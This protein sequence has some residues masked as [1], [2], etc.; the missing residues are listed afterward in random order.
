MEEIKYY[1]ANVDD[2]E[3]LA[4][5]R[6]KFIMEFAGEQP[7]E[8]QNNLKIVLTDYFRT[9][10]AQN[11]CINY[12][13]RSANEIAGTGGLIYRI[14]PGNFKNPTGRSGYIMNMFTLPRFRKK[15]ICTSILNKLID[16][17][18]AEGVILFELHATE[19]GRPIY[20]SNGFKLHPEPTLRRYL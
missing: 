7:E 1:K 19:A 8:D 12:I 6:I 16:D 14:Q 20:L 3:T 18:H 2:A 11:Q 13:A 15:G 9:A 17:A 4:L 10:T 5:L